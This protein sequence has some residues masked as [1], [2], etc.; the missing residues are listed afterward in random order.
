MERKELTP[1]LLNYTTVLTAY[2]KLKDFDSAWSLYE[3]MVHK[4]I[5]PDLVCLNSLLNT[6]AAVQDVQ[7]VCQ[8][9]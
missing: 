8:N 1:D 6:T 2:A 5:K 9:I 4:E 7:K 3:S